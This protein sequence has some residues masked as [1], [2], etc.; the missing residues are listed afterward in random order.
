MFTLLLLTKRFIWSANRRQVVISLVRVLRRSWS[1]RRGRRKKYI[2]IQKKDGAWIRRRE[3]D[4]PFSNI[5]SNVFSSVRN[6]N[7]SYVLVRRGDIAWDTY[8]RIVHAVSEPK[9][10]DFDRS[11]EDRE[12]EE[13]VNRLN[14]K[15]T[16]NCFYKINSIMKKKLGDEGTRTHKKQTDRQ[17]DR[18]IY[19]S[20]QTRPGPCLWPLQVLFAFHEH[21]DRLL[22]EWDNTQNFGENGASDVS[23]NKTGPKGQKIEEGR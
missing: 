21:S 3:T 7:I 20:N 18:Q 5:H 15:N 9:I 6:K 17:T 13:F 10:R 23:N 22:R 11:M 2:W 14:S 8:P 19:K 16:R 1:K 12:N 4:V